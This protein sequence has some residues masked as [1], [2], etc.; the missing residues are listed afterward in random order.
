MT[1]VITYRIQFRL[2]VCEK[3]GQHL[4]FEK[5]C[6]V[7]DVTSFGLAEGSF[8]S[9][10]KPIEN[11]IILIF[12]LVKP[13]CHHMKQI[14]KETHHSYK[15]KLKTSIPRRYLTTTL[16]QIHNALLYFVYFFFI[17]FIYKIDYY[18]YV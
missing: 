15:C 16:Y 3:N 4:S 2:L 7:H 9:I 12:F 13:Q 11:K 5:R 18:D 10:M 6:I 1:S 14:F 17:F 8:K